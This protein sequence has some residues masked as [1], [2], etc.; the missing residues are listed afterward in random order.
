M[1]S[2]PAFCPP[3]HVPDALLGLVMEIWLS[4]ELGIGNTRPDNSARR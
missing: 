3:E 1:T 2:P 4:G